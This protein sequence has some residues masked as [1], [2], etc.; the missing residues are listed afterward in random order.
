MLS[1]KTTRVR[2]QACK[3]PD[4]YSQLQLLAAVRL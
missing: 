4:H 3:H 2:S 1:R